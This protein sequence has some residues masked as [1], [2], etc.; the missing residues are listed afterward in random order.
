MELVDEFKAIYP[1][2]VYFR[3]PQNMGADRNYLKAVE[4]A[5]GDY[6]WLMG[7]DDFV[8]VGAIDDILLRLENS[9][10]Y[11][12]GRVESDFHLNKIR[13]CCW[14]DDR[15]PN[16]DFNFSSELEI[17]RYFNSCRH[18]GGLFSY[19]SS[20]IVKRSSWLRFP[21]DEKFIG[22]LYAHVYVLLSL[23]MSG[24]KLT[25][26]KEPLIVTRSGNDSFLTD[27]IRR[28]LIDFNGYQKLG[29]ELIA[30][31]KI[32]SAFW[33]VMR[34]EHPPINIL[35]SKAM[36]GWD[37]WDEYKKIAKVIYLIP[38]WVFLMSEILYP[39][40]RL[41]YFVKKIYKSIYRRTNRVCI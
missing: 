31:M 38:G 41:A 28:G 22:T 32:R 26:I 40:A 8:P 34:H 21:C 4:I 12:I 37:H 39:P 1:N 24:C 11:M 14:L 20:I 13:D 29:E 23:V 36:S 10:I 25:Y 33:S 17:L 6:C 7:S 2:I 27:W 15:E 5:N 30:D 18:L 9:D 16:Q 19:L 3:W 35:K